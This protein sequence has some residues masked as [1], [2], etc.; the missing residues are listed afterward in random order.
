MSPP[1]QG[2]L[3]GPEGPDPSDEDF[4]TPVYYP[5]PEKVREELHRILAEARAAKTLPWDTG[6][7]ALYRTI[8]PQM[9]GC[10]PEEEGAQLRFDFESELA[11]L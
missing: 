9:T 4:E 8:F 11:R 7:T 6:R 2:D 10:L 5:D 3:F 1:R